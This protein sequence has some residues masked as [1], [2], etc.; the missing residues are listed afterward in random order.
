M[1][2]PNDHDIQ[3]LNGLIG[4]AL[5]SADVYR[6]AAAE[7]EDPSRRALLEERSFARRD[8]AGE[9]QSTVR[10]LGGEPHEGGS[11]LSKGKRA[12]MDVRHALLPETAP[13]DAIEAGESVDQ[14]FEKA[15]ADPRVS[16]TTRETI[17]RAHATVTDGQQDLLDLKHSLESQRDASSDL[18]P[19]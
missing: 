19:N 3:V 5:D 18:F 11:I 7:T 6:D 14:R 12:L 17:R 1:S 8:V 15:L 4:A 2:N 13:I 16:A 9:L 10:A